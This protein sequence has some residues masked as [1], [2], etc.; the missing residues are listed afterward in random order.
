[1]VSLPLYISIYIYCYP[2][3]DCFIVS[4]LISVARH[5]GR[6]K[7][8]LKPAQLYVRLS[9][10]PLSHQ[11]TYVSWG[12]IT[13]YVVAFICLHFC[14]TGYR[15]LNSFK[16]LCITRMVYLGKL[17]INLT[18]WKCTNMKNPVSSEDLVFFSYLYIFRHIYIYIYI[19]LVTRPNIGIMVRLFTNGLGDLGSIPSRAIPKTQKMV[20]DASLFNTQHYKV[21]IK[22]KVEQS[23]ERSHALLY[24]LVL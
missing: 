18:V 3:T 17:E 2:K 24:T 9:I 16:E 22:G 6:F 5:I 21:W 1:M 23:R 4:Q 7:L 14:L 15:V 19:S 10:I 13:Y 20:L 12:I 8:G 11:L